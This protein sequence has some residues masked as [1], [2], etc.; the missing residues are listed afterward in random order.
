VFRT[1][2]YSLIAALLWL[3]TAQ[4]EELDGV[5]LPD[6]LQVDG[7][8]L[9]LN[10]FGLRT[11][12]MLR[13]HIYVV[14]LYLEHLS[15]DAH[16]IIASPE[17]KLLNIRF[18]HNVSADKARKAWREGLENNCRAPCRLDPKEVARF[19]DAV[20]AMHV[21]DNYSLL[22]TQD[23]VI[24][25]VSGRQIG[26]ISQPRFA[27]AMLATFLGPAPASLRLKQDLLRGHE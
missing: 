14:G 20:P 17:T 4:A 13:I 15:T 22:F 19:L 21:D 1:G 26:M 5:Q 6:T 23:G 12:S 25:R 2:A 16:E 7:K 10:G 18:E 8:T 9:H 3:T 27:E 11:Y 24:V